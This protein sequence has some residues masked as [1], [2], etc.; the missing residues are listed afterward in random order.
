MSIQPVSKANNIHP[1]AVVHPKAV[2]SPTATIGPY[3]VV[4]EN[5]VIGDY[6]ELEAHVCIKTSGKQDQVVIGAGTIVH[7]HVSI[8]G[9][10]EFGEK[11]L[12]KSFGYFAGQLV[13]GRSNEFGAHV[14]IGDVNQDKKHVGPALKT[15]IGDNN[16]FFDGVVVHSGS[17]GDRQITS[18]GSRCHL[19]DGS[20]VAH[21]CNVLDD[22]TIGNDVNLGGHVTVEQFAWVGAGT[23]V[24]QFCHI[25][26]HAFVA[27]YTRV[28]HDVPPFVVFLDSLGSINT[29]G[30]KRKDFLQADIV[31]LNKAFKHLFQPNEDQE[32]LFAQRLINV[33]DGASNKSVIEMVDFIQKSLEDK[34][35]RGCYTTAAKR[36]R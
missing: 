18:I 31:A 7:P 8:R 30:L 21:D 5:V 17:S 24:H 25:G 11:C 20:H 12:L 10:V 33:R 22:V 35:R 2:I 23:G 4:S 1:S 32:R 27:G 29:I 3:C 6:A 28:V 19:M 15:V 9:N 26:Q 16:R 14:S 34:N 13:V 36:A